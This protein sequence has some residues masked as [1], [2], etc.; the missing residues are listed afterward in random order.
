M[1][2]RSKI[3]ISLALCSIVILAHTQLACS[4]VSS[5][6]SKLAKTGTV[7]STDS[8]EVAETSTVEES[9]SASSALKNAI[10]ELKDSGGQFMTEA[11]FS[12]IQFVAKKKKSK[13][14]YREIPEKYLLGFRKDWQ[15]EVPI[16]ELDLRSGDLDKQI[17]LYLIIDSDNQRVVQR[18]TEQFEPKF[19]RKHQ[20]VENPHA[21][22]GIKIIPYTDQVDPVSAADAEKD[23]NDKLQKIVIAIH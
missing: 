18:L 2:L 4:P 16:D 12:A 17:R 6:V 7:T 11:D 20:T 21:S 13:T 15:I 10:A 19:L 22:M 14:I 3:E 9:D 1:V 5:S 8:S 23:L